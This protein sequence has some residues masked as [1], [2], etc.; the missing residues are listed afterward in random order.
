M[1]KIIKYYFFLVIAFV[2]CEEIYTPD[3]ESRTGTIVADARIVAGKSD[4]EHFGRK[5][6]YH[7]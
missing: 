4:N 5:C 7:R 2:A 1:N 6:F 3:I